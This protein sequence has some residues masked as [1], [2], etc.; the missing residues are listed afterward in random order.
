MGASFFVTDV[1][2]SETVTV[3]GGTPQCAPSGTTV[4]LRL[5][6]HPQSL[7]RAIEYGVTGSTTLTRYVCDDGISIG[8]NIISRY[9]SGTPTVTCDSANPSC[10]AGIIRTVRIVVPES[11]GFTFSL[12][13]K[14]RVAA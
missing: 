1:Q 13:G 6:W 12:I 8:R 11:N 4:L 14:R 7:T 10:G 3:P 2:S 9:L 5:T